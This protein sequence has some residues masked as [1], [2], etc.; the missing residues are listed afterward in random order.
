MYWHLHIDVSALA[1]WCIGT[2]TLTYYGRQIGTG[3]HYL[4]GLTYMSCMPKR[5]QRHVC[6][7]SSRLSMA[8]AYYSASMAAAEIRLW[9]SMASMKVL[10]WISQPLSQI[11]PKCAEYVHVEEHHNL[12]E[13]SNDCQCHI[14]GPKLLCSCSRPHACQ[15]STG[16]TAPTWLCRKSA[17]L[18]RRLECTN[19]VATYYAQTVSH[20][21]RADQHIVVCWPLWSQMY[22]QVRHILSY[23]IYMVYHEPTDLYTFALKVSLKGHTCKCICYIC[24]HSCSKFCCAW[25]SRPTRA[26]RAANWAIQMAVPHPEHQLLGLHQCCISAAELQTSSSSACQLSQASMPY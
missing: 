10:L 23:I 19:D 22:K 14:P 1:H 11:Q 6:E 7:T 5:C 17:Q 20:K 24:S 16:M 2:C 15:L 8:Q 18:C 25:S 12:I 21:F 13:I 9:I 4:S 3:Q 26:H